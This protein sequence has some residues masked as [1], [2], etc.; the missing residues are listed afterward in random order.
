MKLCR[1][2]TLGIGLLAVA[3][4]RCT[5]EYNP[6]ADSDNAV[7]R[8]AEGSIQ[9]GD[10][11]SIFSA[12]SIAVGIAVGGLLD[13]AIISASGNRFWRDTTLRP[14]F[15]SGLYHLGVSFADTGAAT[16]RLTSYRT[17]GEAISSA[18]HLYVRSPLRQTAINGYF[19]K[20]IGLST[21]AVADPDILYHWDFGENTI[22][23]SPLPETTAVI[24]SANASGTGMLWVSDA[25]RDVRSPASPFSF[26]L[27]DTLPPVI[28]CVN[29]GSIR[30]DTV[31]TGEHTFAFRVRITDREDNR[32]YSATIDGVPFDQVLLEHHLYASVYD[33]M[34]AYG[35]DNPRRAIVRAVDHPEFRNEAIDTFWLVYDPNVSAANE[36]ALTILIPSADPGRTDV[37]DYFM[38][39][40]IEDFTRDSV[41]LTIRANDGAAD[42][43]VVAGGQTFWQH[44][45]RLDPD[46]TRVSV[47]A[48]SLEGDSLVSAT[49]TIVYDSDYQ[50]ASAPVIWR[51]TVDGLPVG[52]GY[53]RADSA[54]LRVIAFDD[55]AGI[56]EVAVNGQGLSPDNPATH[57]TAVIHDLTHAPAGNRITVQALDK[58]GNSIDSTCIIKHNTP[59]SLIDDSWDMPYLIPVNSRYRDTLQALDIDRTRGGAADSVVF[60]KAYGPEGVTVSPSGVIDWT[61]ASP[62]LLEDSLVIVLFD[63]YEAREFTR[64]FRVIDPEHKESSVRFLNSQRDFPPY[65]E[66]DA[67]T[68]RL[69][70]DVVDS[71]GKP[72]Y[73]YAARI[74]GQSAFMYGPDSLGAFAWRP[75]PSDTGLKRL[76]LTV[77]DAYKESDTL[78]AMVRVVPR[79]QPCSLSLT[80]TGAITEQSAIDLRACA[81][82]DTLILRIADPDLPLLGYAEWFSASVQFANQTYA[83]AV[84]SLG[85]ARLTLDPRTGK[86][87]R[88]TVIARIADRKGHADTAGFAVDYGVP[89]PTPAPDAPDRGAHIDGAPVTLRWNSPVSASCPYWYS[90]DFGLDDSLDN[91]ADSISD[92]SLLI[93]ALAVTGTYS[94]RVTVSDGRSSVQGPIQRFSYAAPNGVR[95]VSAERDFPRYLQA[96]V[97]SVSMVLKIDGQTGRPPFRYSARVTP[98]DSL[99]LD[100][101]AEN[102]LHW[103]PGEQLRGVHRL[104]IT[105]TDS[106]RNADT[107]NPVIQIV[108][109]NQ[110]PC[111]L[112]YAFSGLTTDGALDMRKADGPDTVWFSIHDDDHPVTESYEVRL[113]HGFGTTTEA[114]DTV[115]HF[116]LYLRPHAGQG[117]PDTLAVSVSDRTGFRDSLRLPVFAGSNSGA[118]AY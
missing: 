26:A 29:A 101:S 35:R 84:D 104:T 116:A 85:C 89:L 78:A 14:P 7:A 71:T 86:S 43:I 34:S 36:T 113:S 76:I 96:G 33:S 73:Q 38:Y 4:P 103:K 52:A 102:L 66:A 46:T 112:S 16:L 9:D 98:S 111:S 61:P 87:G 27:G 97:D 47:T 15:A 90:V 81:T 39:G 74:A 57:W 23:S 83:L 65:L 28:I 32:V 60:Q 6:F 64:R 92:S 25:R 108:P 44:A 59:P 21:P 20:T 118:I 79:N 5:T 77:T 67:D 100:A 2:L 82:P 10:T 11:V 110:Y 68:F 106:S 13:S 99:L 49:R 107:I 93:G 8:L 22:I 40:T 94:W 114:I 105:V 91:I 19:G 80:Y 109:R 115:R 37:A 63:G 69:R 70:L 3:L 24:Q 95:F 1:T 117:A 50:D 55:G 75:A 88:D 30:K 58:A 41:L 51:I 18:L 54:L 72:P 53:V 48:R 31:L 56:D 62:S 12:E 42:A 45:L 17:N